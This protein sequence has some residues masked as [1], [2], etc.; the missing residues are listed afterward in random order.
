MGTFLFD[1]IIFGPVYSRRL[2]QSLGLNL[3][4]PGLKICTFNCVYCECGWTQN[5]RGSFFSPTDFETA[6]EQK[7]AQMVTNQ[8]AA[9]ALTFAGNGEPTLHPQFGEIMEI[10]IKLRDRYM[11]GAHVAVLSNSTT[12]DRPGVFEALQKADMAIMKLDAGS[13]QMF[14][15]I[16][17]PNIS[18]TLKEIVQQLKRFKGNLIV[19]TLLCK[20]TAGK[21]IIDNSTP[22]EL[23][24]L[25]EK[26]QEIQPHTVMLYSIAR[27]TPLESLSK[28]DEH[29]LNG[30]ASVLKKYIPQSDIQ[31]Y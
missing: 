11:K 10:T 7:L 20:G 21:E 13:E 18:I 29:E 17:Q 30:A 1:N 23:H 16:N 25:G 2:G 24:L 5:N 19:Q 6:L 9:D 28:T 4:P 3:L 22:D 31:I 26:L 27:G 8:V 15:I 12:L 14:R